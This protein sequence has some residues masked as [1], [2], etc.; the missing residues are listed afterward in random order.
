MFKYLRRWL[1]MV[2]DDVHAVRAQLVKARRV[3]ACISAILNGE[4]TLDAKGLQDIRP[5]GGP[6]CASVWKWILG[7]PFSFADLPGGVP[8]PHGVAHGMGVQA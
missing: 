8:H 6:E 5:G 7:P 1:A 3:W 4:N 2:D